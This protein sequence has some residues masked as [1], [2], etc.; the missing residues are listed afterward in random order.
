MVKYI[1][2]SPCNY[3]VSQEKWGENATQGMRYWTF[4]GKYF[5]NDESRLK[6]AIEEGEV[7]W[8]LAHM[9]LIP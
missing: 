6:M 4:C 9:N 3:H 2:H 8:M 1:V 5:G 7:I